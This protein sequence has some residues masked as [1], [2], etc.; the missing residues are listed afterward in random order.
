[1][2]DPAQSVVGWNGVEFQLESSW[3]VMDEINAE[4]NCQVHTSS[5]L[6]RKGEDT[7]S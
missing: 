5:N 7:N 4:N 3:N 2:G 1:M 6:L